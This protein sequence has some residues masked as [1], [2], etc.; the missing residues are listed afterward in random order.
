MEAK[1]KIGKSW[2][3][4]LP[5]CRNVKGL[6]I[7]ARLFKM[8]CNAAIKPVQSGRI[9]RV[10]LVQLH[11]PVCM[12]NSAETICEFYELNTFHTVEVETSKLSQVSTCMM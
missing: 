8:C 6:Q 11:P 3:M 7:R 2:A 10:A 1:L 9:R 5:T 4:K 12:Q